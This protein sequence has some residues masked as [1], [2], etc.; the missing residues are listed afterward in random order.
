MKMQYI[1]ILEDA[2]KKLGLNI[3]FDLLNNDLL[4]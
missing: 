4:S 3:L 2:R 1:F